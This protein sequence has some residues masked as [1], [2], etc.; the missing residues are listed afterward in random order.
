[1][2]AEKTDR[3]VQRRFR[4]VRLTVLV[5]L[6][7]GA[8]AV[9]VLHQVVQGTRPVGVDALC[10]FGAIEAALTLVQTGTLLEKIAWS[11]FVLLGAAVLVALVFRRAFCG[12]I[13]AFGALQELSGRLGRALFGRRR[14]VVPAAV[15]RPARYLKYLV[16]VAVVAGTAAT[17]T[18]FIRPY[19]PWATWNHLLSVELLTGF[20][21]GLVVLAVSLAGSLVYE[22]F[23]CKYLC[24]MGAFLGL[25]N[26]LGWFRVRRNEATCTHCLACNR[27]CPV[28]LP[29]E[30]LGEVKS[31]ECLNC[32]LC[33]EACPVKDT[34]VTSGPKGRRVSSFA[35]L[36]ITLAIFLAVVGATTALGSYKWVVEGLAER[37]SAGGAERETAAA[38]APAAGGAVPADAGQPAA[39]PAAGLDPQQIKGSDTFRQVS[40]VF[41]VPQAALVERF[42]ISEEEFG[43]AI[44]DV[45]H[46]PDSG[47]DVQAVRDFVAERLK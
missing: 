38:A 4:A 26:R 15:D 22:R 14:P 8:T 39:A 45:S 40:E 3:N 17:G 9:A 12:Q 44:R 6:L 21:V 43:G 27:A 20:L 47:F 7:V 37:A 10:P 33:V 30:S 34:L 41:G 24:P 5:V 46:R 35:V 32:N 36:G 1:M 31:A 13:C 11:S 29:V 19:D 18:L 25:I 28:N 16:L 42:R 23:F 2:L